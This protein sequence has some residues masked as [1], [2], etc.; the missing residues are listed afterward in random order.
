MP[1]RS[2]VGA[3]AILLL[4][5]ARASDAGLIHI[6]TSE[7][8]AHRIARFLS[9]LCPR[10]EVEVF[11]PWDCLPYDRAFPSHEVMGKRMAV[12]ESLSA[13]HPSRARIVVTT[14]DALLQ[15]VPRREALQSMDLRPGEKIDPEA[16]R[17]FCTAGGYVEDER[18]DEPGE[19]AFR[20]EVIDIFPAG[21]PAPCR[22]EMIDARITSIRR[23][24]PV[25]QRTDGD[26]ERLH[27][28]TSS[29]LTDAG[30]GVP[31]EAHGARTPHEDLCPVF[32][33]L[34]GAAITIEAGA[35]DRCEAMIAQIREAYEDRLKTA[36]PGDHA[37]APPERLY[38]TDEEWR[39]HVA[40]RVESL[41]AASRFGPVPEFAMQ[42]RSASAL[43]AFLRKRDEEKNRILLVG[44]DDRD[45][46]RLA[47]RAGRTL[48][49]K[50][51]SA[52]S[53][54]EVLQQPAGSIV[55]L[56]ADLE[57]GLVD[58]KSRV[59]VIAVHDVLGSRASAGS[60]AADT[61]ALWES[62]L[63]ELH[64]GDLVV[65]LDHGIGILEGLEPLGASGGEGEAIRLEYADATRLM[66]PVDEADRIWRYG[67]DATSV[68]LDR[69]DAEGW[70]KRRAKLRSALEET[71]GKIVET[72]RERRARDAARLV[73]PPRDYERF[74]GRFP[75]AETADQDRAIKAVLDDLSSGK[76]MD[77]LVLGDVGFGKTEVALRAAAAAAFSGKQV[78]V[79]VPTTVLARQHYETFRR[80]FLPF[81]IRVAHL[82]R[83]VSRKEADAVKAGLA[84]GS[85]PIVVG[86]HAVA[87]KGIEFADLGLLIIDEE[88]KFGAA[89]K[90][91]LRAMGS[92]VHLL[93]LS[94]TPIPRTLQGALAGLQDMSPIMTP[95]SRR[96]PVRTFSSPYDAATAC[97][98]LRREKRRG[99]Q[100]FLVVP[101]IDD[102]DP[103]AENLK[104]LAPDLDVRIAHGELP[105]KDVDESM[106]AFAAGSGDVL[107]ATSIIES[108]LDVPRANTMIV[109][110]ADLFGMAELHQLRGRVGRSHIQA[111]CYLTTEPDQP[112]S[113]AV[114]RRLGTLQA[115][116]RLGA[117][118][119]IA[120]R[121]LD[122]RGGGDLAGEKQAG[123]VKLVGLPLYQD[124][125]SRA[126][127]ES[128]GEAPDDRRTELQLELSPLIPPDYIPEAE[129][130][131][132][133]YHRL[134]HASEQR[135]V[136]R[137]AAE[138]ADRFGPP[139]DQVRSL[140]DIARIRTMAAAIGIA[141]LAA[142][143]QAV[144]LTFHAN[145]AAEKELA[146]VVEQD[147][148]LSW[149]EGRL[150]CRRTADDRLPRLGAVVEL[151]D[152]L[153]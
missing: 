2:P 24:D 38:L 101:R 12:L 75:F 47:D 82:S 58:R 85:I 29:E 95:P 76:P 68:S 67:S 40:A 74:V 104:E 73:P 16:V 5:R 147:P 81:G 117:G 97:L 143:P 112:L 90:D 139:P 122:Q 54:E 69:L 42:P 3:T 18:V 131:L 19:V 148:D 28:V 20:G 137:L 36:G 125:L 108:G 152:Q 144:A 64:T 123:H 86:T 149:N 118:M 61:G 119:A 150:I 60:T 31:Q 107:L 44:P 37:P 93:S 103:I 141:K 88:Q 77:R 106:V 96:R 23:Y 91:K 62:E 45:L 21:E 153:S 6:T 138:I 56:K 124:L 14:P 79:V 33:Y 22:I 120:A 1:D 55:A 46:S 114:K 116:D 133:L 32:D 98:A 52:R 136:E 113:E 70:A 15:R 27:V 135:D 53:W 8:R 145:V 80:R 142:G 89:Q 115:Y 34:P 63:S 49:R 127:K 134:A 78:A 94:A 9:A 92:G 41:D 72:H 10:N 84:D 71:A 43:A 109:H 87:G 132:N 100:S 121:D 128:K 102:I 83:L 4:E 130:R 105:P 30:D 17:S 7:A 26:L 151:L 111:L 13:G 39:D 110:R 11:P 57:R 129:M 50:P 146:D 25:S 66:V 140:L 126:L 48:G 35:E 59:A 99:G 65:H 51:A